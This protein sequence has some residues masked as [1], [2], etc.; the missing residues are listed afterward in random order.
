MFRLL[1]VI[2]L[3]AVDTDICFFVLKIYVTN[4]FNEHI[5]AYD[6]T[7]AEDWLFVS[8]PELISFYPTSCRTGSDG[9][10]Y[11]TFRHSL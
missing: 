10:S 9:V 1:I 7:V 5:H 11:V 2:F 6:V 8:Y 4:G 3:H